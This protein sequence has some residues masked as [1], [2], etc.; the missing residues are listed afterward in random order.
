MLK[1]SVHEKA[2][3]FWRTPR[4][5]QNKEPQALAS[6]KAG[7]NV[8][9]TESDALIHYEY[10]VKHGVGED[11]SHPLSASEVRASNQ[12]CEYGALITQALHHS[13]ARLFHCWIAL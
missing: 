12:C 8:P 1:N 2:L 3:V 6:S 4:K 11:S 9:K 10:C 7:N 5:H 13:V